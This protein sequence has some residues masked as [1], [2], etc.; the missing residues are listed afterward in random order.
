MTK[1]QF[2]ASLSPTNREIARKY[3]ISS[4]EQLAEVTLLLGD[5]AS[6]MAKS[7]TPVVKALNEF[8]ENLPDIVGQEMGLKGRS[9]LEGG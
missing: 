4:H 6:A 9:E 1:E 2:Y 3:G 8:I 5:F 7:F